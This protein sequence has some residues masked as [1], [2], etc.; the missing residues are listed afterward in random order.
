MVESRAEFEAQFQRRPGGGPYGGPVTK[1][2]D[3]AQVDY[4]A[5]P[6][7]TLTAGRFLTPFGI[8]NERLYPVWIHACSLI[9]LFFPSTRLRAME[10]CFAAASRSA[11]RPT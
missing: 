2:V 5:N 7:L 11:Q 3:Y 1:H 4:I 9:P 10:P 8:F 6:Y